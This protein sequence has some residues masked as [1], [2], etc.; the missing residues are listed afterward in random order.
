M[1][2]IEADGWQYSVA[3]STATL[4]ADGQTLTDAGT[5]FTRRLGSGP[6]IDGLWGAILTHDGSTF[7]EERRYRSDGTF[8]V[9]V[10]KDGVFE[11]LTFGTYTWR[12]DI[13]ATRERRAIVTTGPG[14][15]IDFDIPFGL[16]ATGTY[17][18]TGPDSWDLTLGAT[19]YSFTRS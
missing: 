19:T 12:N 10:M 6:G 9:Q 13:L 7:D 2:L 1:I 4:S 11:T 18:F 17:A 3:A 15:S 8:T 5:P 16:D 14:N